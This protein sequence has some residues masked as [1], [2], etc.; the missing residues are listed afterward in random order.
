MRLP[1]FRFSLLGLMALV[2]YAAL[3]CAA[4]RYSTDWWASGIF[5]L[6]VLSQMLAVLC[7]V[8]RH[9]QARAAWIGFLVFGGGYLLLSS[10]L[11]PLPDLITHR[12]LTWLQQKVQPDASVDAALAI[13][14]SNPPALYAYGTKSVT[15]L[16][17]SSLLLTRAVIG[18]HPDPSVQPPF[19]R[20][21]HALLSPLFGLIGVLIASWLFAGRKPTA[22]C[23]KHL[24]SEI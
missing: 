24:E 19:M 2:A 7:V 16:T 21:G 10:G 8:L 4:L 1:R 13:T 5:T 20:I 3:A 22:E 11:W 23:E 17:A 18:N 14:S 9:D 6:V 12:G 15:T